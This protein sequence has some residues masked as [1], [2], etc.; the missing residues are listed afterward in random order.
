MASKDNL[1]GI[2]ETDVAT[3]P[4]QIQDFSEYQRCLTQK[5][6]QM[7]KNPVPLTK[8]ER[9]W[10]L[11]HDK[12]GHLTFA[13]MERL[14]ENNMLPSKFRKLKA[15]LI[16]F[17]S[18]IFGRMRRRAWRTKSSKSWKHIRR[19][20]LNVPGAKVSTDQLVVAQPGIVPRI[21]GRHT[22]A[23]ICGATGFYD[24]YSGNSYSSI[25]TSLDGN[26][27]LAAKNS[28][29]SHAATCGVQISLNRGNNGRFAEKSF[30]GSIKAA[31]QTIDF[32]AV[33]AHHQNSSIIE[34]HF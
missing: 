23:R 30:V 2:D 31:H 10:K 4:I 21:S 7:L 1:Q 20:D 17:P 29:E 24:N 32:C 27:T 11:M 18:C 33:G 19:E 15:K 5:E 3:I 16:I 22:N 14:V 12:L 6:I 25:Q 8:L 9:D 13:T 28:F 34:R 26:Q